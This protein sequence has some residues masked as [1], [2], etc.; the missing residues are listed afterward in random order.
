[1]S[2]LQAT[3]LLVEDE[4]NDIFLIRRAF[5][6]AEAGSIIHA[7]ADGE[8]AMA[9]LTGEGEF[10]NR[11]QYPLPALILLDVKLPRK[12]GLE[13]LAWLRGQNSFLRRV[14]IIVLTSSKQAADIHRAYELGANSYLVKPVAFEGLVEMV[15]AIEL[16]WMVLN[17]R[18][19][20]L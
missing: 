16:Y 13:V 6:K 7:V 14:P 20:E 4:P 5:R 1:M 15:K 9:Y 8:Q 19:E 17:E 10:A 18:P 3:I 11:N 2:A 12:S